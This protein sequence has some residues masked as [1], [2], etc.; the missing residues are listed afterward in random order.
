MNVRG[1]GVRIEVEVG[2]L[3]KECKLVFFVLAETFLCS[4]CDVQVE[5]YTV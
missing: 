3:I 5:G 4:E 2:Q 1:A